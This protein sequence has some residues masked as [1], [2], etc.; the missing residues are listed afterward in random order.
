MERISNATCHSATANAYHTHSC[1]YTH[2]HM[3]KHTPCTYACTCTVHTT[4]T[5]SHPPCTFTHATHTHC[6]DI[7]EAIYFEVQFTTRPGPARPARAAV[8]AARPPTAHRPPCTPRAAP[9]R[10]SWRRRPPC[11]GGG[12]VWRQSGMGFVGS[13]VHMVLR[14]TA[15]ELFSFSWSSL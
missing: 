13:G 9:C 4:H 10:R 8:A 2:V 15:M 3:H 5:F 6:G 11:R 14:C 7:D 1:T 12:P